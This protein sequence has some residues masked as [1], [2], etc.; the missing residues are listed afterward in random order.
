MQITILT[1]SPEKGVEH[2][3]ALKD[4]KECTS[5]KIS[6]VDLQSDDPDEIKAIASHFRLHEL[7]VEDCLTPGHFPKLEDFGS[8]LFMIFRA[9]KAS[10][11]VEQIWRSRL[12]AD[13]QVTEELLGD[14]DHEEVFTRKV[15]VFLSDKFIITFRRRDVPWL[16][17]VTRQVRQYPERTIAQG[18]DVVGHRVLD[19]LFDRFARG[20]GFFENLIDEMELQAIADQDQFDVRQVMSL[21]KDLAS[22]RQLMREQRGVVARL[23]SDADFIHEKQRRYYRDIDDHALSIIKTI[24]KEIDGLLGLRDTYFAMANVRLGD[25]MRIL[26]VITTLA[27]PLNIVVGLYGMNFEA[28][29]L[30]HSPHGFWLVCV[31]MIVLVGLMLAFFRRKQWL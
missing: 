25:T 11:E 29:P 17:A 9:I 8:Y 28:I 23:G 13:P 3:E 26:A 10:P 12:Q 18:T 21:K 19:V 7:A 14:E 16:D 5:A 15:A 20:V 4:L 31:T 22:L 27:A 30:L 2:F 24:D 1:Y 6:W